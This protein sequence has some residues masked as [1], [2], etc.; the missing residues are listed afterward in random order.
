MSNGFVD[1]VTISVKAGRGGANFY[2]CVFAFE[3][4]DPV[5]K[6][7][8]GTDVPYFFDN[9]YLAPC[10]YTAKNKAEAFKVSDTCG[11]AWANFARTGDP[12]GR[13]MPKWLPYEQG[14]RYTMLI[15]GESELVSNYRAK[16]RELV[17][18]MEGARMPGFA[19]N[20]EK[21]D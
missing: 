6:A 17:Y 2:N 21:E 20:D 8:H 12:T 15:K 9:A 4:P 3:S 14:T 18:R 1:K 16:G 7:F 19:R 10:T 11:S 5:Q 13:N